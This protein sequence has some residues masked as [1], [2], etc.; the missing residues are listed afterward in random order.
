MFDLERLINNV[1]KKSKL[2]QVLSIEKGKRKLIFES[3]EKFD[4]FIEG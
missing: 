1:D 3:E 4:K 2:R